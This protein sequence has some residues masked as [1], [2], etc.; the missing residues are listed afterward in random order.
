MRQPLSRHFGIA[1]QIRRAAVSIPA[2]IAEG[3]ALGTTRQLMRCLRIAHGSAAE[4]LCHLRIARDLGLGAA[5]ETEAALTLCD[6]VIALLIG[7]LRGLSRLTA[8]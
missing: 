1:D 2:N 3:Y 4:L 7:T 8:R 5:G 6:R